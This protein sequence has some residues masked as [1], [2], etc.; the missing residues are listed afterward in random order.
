MNSHTT[1]PYCG[2]GC[3]VEVIRDSGQIS[4]VKGD[5]KHPANFGRLCVKG[6]SLH[7]TLD[8]RGRLLK[9]QVDGL[10]AHWDDA[11]NEVAARFQRTVEEHGPD[12]V[13]MYLSGQL[14]T[15]DYYVANKLMKGF[16]GT[17]NIDTNSRLCMASTVVG[18]KRAFGSDT[19][20]CSYDDIEL[21]NLIVLVGSNTA[22]NHPI[23]FQRMVL[24]K[25]N[26]PNLKVVVIDPRETATCKLADIHLALKPGSD[27]R[28]FNGLLSWLAANGHLDQD[29]IDRFTDGFE[30]ALAAAVNSSADPRQLAEDCDLPVESLHSFFNWF[31][32][33]ENVLT[34]FSQGTNQ[35]ASGVD[36][37]NA[38]TNCH[39]ATG[40]VG[41]PGQGPFSLTGQPNA[42]G[43]REVGGLA[44]QLAAHMDFDA[45][46]IDRVERFW[47]APNMATKPGYKAV[48]LFQ[49]IERGEVKAVWIMA[50]NPVV[51]LPDADQIKRA[52]EK[53]ETVVVSECVADSDTAKFADIL[54]PATGW[55]EKD[56]TV[57]NSERR[58]SRQ[59]GLI[60]MSG[61]ARHDWWI[62]C[63]VAKRMGYDTEFS[64]RHPSEIFAEHAALSGFENE[65][66]RDF[67]ISYFSNIDRF[68][69]DNLKPIQWPV[70]AECP[71]GTERMFADGKFFTPTGRARFVEIIPRAPV[72]QPT[73]RAPLVMN[74]G[75]IRDQWHTMTRTGTAPRL[76]NHREEPFVEVHP[77][78]AAIRNISDG[79]LVKV[80]NP[81]ADYYARTRIEEGQRKGEIFVPMHWNEA[82]ASQGRMGA[83]V[84]PVTDPLSGQPELKHAAVQMEPLNEQWEGWLIT[85][86]SMPVPAVDYWARIPKTNTDAYHVAG[87]DTVDSWQQWCQ[88]H[89]GEPDL[90]IE[91]PAK[92]SFRAAGFMNGK[93]NWVLLITPFNNFPSADWIDHLFVQ[94]TLETQQYQYLL[95]ATNVEVEDQG[96]IICSCYQV[97]TTAID[98]AIKSGCGSA[99]ELGEKLQ[100]G[101]NCGSCIPELEGFFT[102]A[103]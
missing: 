47:D 42:M 2:V 25:K 10:P 15:E 16:I 98:K 48:D 11:L 59:R 74:T 43:G 37:V 103:S 31:G 69:Y 33:T 100:C 27:T 85:T 55:S 62:M 22:W 56:G 79:M 73:D 83:L 12:S 66:Q 65:G 18:Y 75:R 49:A 81:R 71:D 60:P 63:E 29:Y 102:R 9:P 36:N 32:A 45:E 13:A 58:I 70:T 4:G 64:Y 84:A 99:V 57:T 61:E 97:G 28:L 88:E 38:I 86:K 20:P 94:E 90:W 8:T 46:S 52:L 80:S 77:R 6:S 5:K 7:E 51:S 17:A 26:N 1:C 96:T 78:D 72:Q 39:L 21:A 87:L 35:S 67:D 40:R 101:T 68:T 92:R 14:L 53:C 76:F 44:N 82:F 93:L 54:L 19:V 34:F 41:Q 3:G 24:A 30:Y 95:S 89:L 91:D 50:T 23:L